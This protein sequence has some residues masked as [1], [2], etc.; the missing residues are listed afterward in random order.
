[1]PS[2]EALL[3]RRT[4][5]SAFVVHFTRATARATASDNLKA[6]LEDRAIEA[7]NVFGMAI[8]LHG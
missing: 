5:L 2:I 4:D 7:R 3:H 8:D 6:I 1:M